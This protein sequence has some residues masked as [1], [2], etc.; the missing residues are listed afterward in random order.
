MGRL[1][2]VGL[3]TGEIATTYDAVVLGKVPLEIHAFMENADNIN[4]VARNA[5]E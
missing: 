2:V 4:S 3:N 1:R 5:V